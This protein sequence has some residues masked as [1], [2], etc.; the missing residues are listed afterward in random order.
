MFTLKCEGVLFGPRPLLFKQYRY[1]P[2]V[3][4]FP[5]LV[6]ERMRE[7]GSTKVREGDIEKKRCS[8]KIVRNI[9]VFTRHS[10]INRTRN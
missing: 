4:R 9:I 1:A 5:I 3:K 2:L 10:S 6:R 8:S 7:T